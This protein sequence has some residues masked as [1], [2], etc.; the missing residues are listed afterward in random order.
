MG[1]LLRRWRE[2]RG[3]TQP[4]AALIL[5]ISA[6]TYRGWESGRRKPQLDDSVLPGI[7][8]VLGDLG[9][10]PDGTELPGGPSME[11][12]QRDVSLT[13]QAAVRAAVDAAF[14]KIKST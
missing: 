4:N 9:I 5:G 10:I 8:R 12:L 2:V 3:I 1:R 11:D 14:A 6:G 13:A 7:L